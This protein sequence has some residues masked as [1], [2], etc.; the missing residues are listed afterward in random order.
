[1]DIIFLTDLD[2]E[3]NLSDNVSKIHMPLDELKKRFSQRLGVD[4]A[5]HSYYKLCDLKPTY[6]YVFYEFIKDYDFWGF[7]DIDLMYGDTS[8]F[9]TQDLFDHYDVLTFRTDWLSGALTFFRNTPHINSL[10]KESAHWKKVVTESRHFS[11]TEC[12]KQYSQLRNG[13]SIFELKAEIESMTVVCKRAAVNGTLRLYERKLIKESIDKYEFLKFE[14]GAITDNNGNE[15]L[16]YHYITEKHKRRFSFP[17]WEEIPDLFWITPSGFY[18]EQNFKL[19]GFISVYREV[20]GIVK[21]L[22]KRL[23]GVSID[24]L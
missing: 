6:G 17:G 14:D 10:F 20:N 18:T 23:K 7:G 4:V 1:M 9:I 13:V 8:K 15:Y 12:A 2:L 3:I 16:L 5:M 19:R 22:K 21:K 11:F 24:S